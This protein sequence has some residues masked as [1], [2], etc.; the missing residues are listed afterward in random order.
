MGPLLPVDALFAGLDVGAH[1]TSDSFQ[2]KV[3]FV[4]LLN[5]PLTDLAERIKDGGNYS[6]RNWAEVR[7]A[8]RFGSRVPAEIRQEVAKVG[9]EADLYISQYN[10]WMHHLLT[11]KGERLFPSRSRPDLATGTCGTS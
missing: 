6:R 7:L 2:N 1:L 4:V 5:F 11:P 3:A 10:I 8:Q 9:A